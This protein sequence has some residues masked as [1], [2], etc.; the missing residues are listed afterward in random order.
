GAVTWV[1][2][3][4]NNSG[5]RLPEWN[6]P[7]TSIK[8]RKGPTLASLSPSKQCLV[9]KSLLFL[10]DSHLQRTLT[11][12]AEEFLDSQDFHQVKAMPILCENMTAG[13]FVSLGP[14]TISSPVNQT[15]VYNFTT[16]G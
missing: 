5:C 9:G 11:H 2:S 7:K 3:E 8:K 6:G 16:P 13:E 14:N 12:L 1:P 10:G 15:C 4:D